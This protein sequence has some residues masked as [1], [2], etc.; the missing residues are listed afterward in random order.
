MKADIPINGTGMLPQEIEAEE[1]AVRAEAL[2]RDARLE[3]ERKRLAY[4]YENMEHTAPV[5]ED[6][7]PID[8]YE[9][10]GFFA[11]ETDKGP[12]EAVASPRDI[13]APQTTSSDGSVESPFPKAASEG[14]AT[15][16]VNGVSSE[17][18]CSTVFNTL[19][20]CNG[21]KNILN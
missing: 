7:S 19:K 9:R 20:S 14:G 4:S 12:T 5:D 16:H 18:Y 2:E 10:L 3:A 6:G 13:E 1:K 8:G 17:R 21:S 11:E 15:N